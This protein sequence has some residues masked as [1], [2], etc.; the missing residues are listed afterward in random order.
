VAAKAL[1]DTGR[2]PILITG[3]GT[4]GYLP[5]APYD[6]VLATVAVVDRVPYE[7]IAQTRPGG[8]VVTPWGSEYCNGALLRLLV[9]NDGTASGRFSGNLAF[10][11]LR[12]QRTAPHSNNDH[13]EGDAAES[14]TELTGVEVYEMISF[15]RAAFACR[16]VN[17][18]SRTI[19]MTT[20]GTSF[21]AGPGVGILGRNG[22]GRYATVRCSPVRLTSTVE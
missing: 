15:Q 6:R 20:T 22:G 11:R 14:T 3:D 1:H 12:G 8:L 10:M 18:V 19:P 4:A 16:P 21:T 17:C 9:G 2:H 7:W 13:V 5:A